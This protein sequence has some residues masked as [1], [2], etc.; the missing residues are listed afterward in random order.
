M[1]TKPSNKMYKMKNE[2]NLGLFSNDFSS[3]Y[4]FINQLNISNL[5]DSESIETNIL[6]TDSLLQTDM[7][8]Q[9]IIINKGYI[10]KE[11]NLNK[12]VG[13]ISDKFEQLSKTLKDIED[14][15]FEFINNYT[16]KNFDNYSVVITDRIDTQIKKNIINTKKNVFF[17]LDRE[18]VCEKLYHHLHF[19]E[20]KIVQF[21]ILSIREMV[22]LIL[23]FV[24]FDKSYSVD[25]ISYRFKDYFELN[26]NNGATLK[27]EK[28]NR[29]LSDILD[30]NTI[31]KALCDI[32]NFQNIDIIYKA[33]K[34]DN[35]ISIFHKIYNEKPREFKSKINFLYSFYT[36][37]KLIFPDFKHLFS[38]LQKSIFKNEKLF[39][40]E[41]TK[42][43]NVSFCNI[44]LSS[45]FLN[46]SN[47]IETIAKLNGI[48]VSDFI[49]NNNLTDYHKSLSDF[50]QL[51]LQKKIP[52]S[53]FLCQ[54]LYFSKK[55]FFDD[56]NNL[57][58]D[59]F[60]HSILLLIFLHTRS[61]KIL[62]YLSNSYNA[63]SCN[64]FL[65][66]F[67]L[68]ALNKN[69]SLN[70]DNHH[71]LIDFFLNKIENIDWISSPSNI[72]RILFYC[73]YFK[74]SIFY[75]Y[76]QDVSSNSFFDKIAIDYLQKKY[77]EFI[78]M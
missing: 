15:N 43:K 74:I 3:S 46:S 75:H 62:T 56:D 77:F 24:N 48:K 70:V 49:L 53:D 64:H 30:F 73:K 47:N 13:I 16:E 29:N 52:L 44:K 72:S 2:R 40:F 18:I 26:G 11:N 12:R 76:F 7:E 69:I 60:P 78:E 59:N 58:L 39:N 10:L 66:S 42:S 37:N 63:S 6:P 34:T 33:S 61:P 14:I 32:N 55:D 25:F 54:I 4:D 5:N 28:I 38:K 1:E 31:N 23:G 45:N 22:K 51:F 9:K 67:L 50:V 71:L 21:E 27:S 20:H 57:D 19:I 8:L 68:P 35:L 41:Y 17:I 65:L 36:L